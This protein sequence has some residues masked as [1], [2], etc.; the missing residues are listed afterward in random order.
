[1]AE[2]AM[3]ESIAAQP[4]LR[5]GQVVVWVLVAM[6]LLFITLG[7]ASAFAEPPVDGREAP[8]FT[9]ATYSGE[10]FTLSEHQGK[11]VV[12]NFWA[13]WCAPCKEEA[14]ELQ[15]AWVDYQERG[16]QFVGV[17]YVDAEAP[18]RAYLAE[19]AI[20]YPNGA[21]LGTKI[22][23]AY[24]IRGVPETFI[25]NRAG[26]VVFY[27]ANPITYEQLTAEIDKALAE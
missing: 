4:K 11:V 23:D 21:D 16:V 22:S 14:A 6:V 10:E 12:I 15:Q 1:M 27:V 19:F 5:V 2:E 20:T 8:D 13:S 7:L 17:D 3:N 26:E 24:H 18:A 25:V 9:M